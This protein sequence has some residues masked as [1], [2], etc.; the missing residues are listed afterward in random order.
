M[1]TINKTDSKISKSLIEVWQW[2]ERVY[3]DIKDKNFTEKSKYYEQGLNEAVKLLNGQ[4]IKNVDGSYMLIN[5]S[6]G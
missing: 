6:E 3:E 1:K 4:L 5:R 2:K